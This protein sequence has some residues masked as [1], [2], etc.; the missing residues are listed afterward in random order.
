M[1][2]T[3][4]LASQINNQ[5]PSELVGF[6]K[7]AGETA[8]GRGQKLY[9]VGGV[10]RDLLLKRP[11]LD[12]DL[13]VVGNAIALADE[14]AK[15]KN[16]KVIAHTRFNTAKIR[17]DRWSVDIA[18]TRSEIYEKP[19][20]LPAVQCGGD[21]EGDLIRR[22]FTINAMAVDLDPDHFGGVID[23]F[24]GREDLEGGYIRILHDSSFKD[25]ATRIW[26][27]VR[28]EQRLD[29]NIEPHTL[30]LLKQDITY[31]DAISGDRIRHELELCLEE[32][33]PD[34]VLL[35]ANTFGLLGRICPSLEVAEWAAKKIA[36][37][38]G[39]LQPYSPPEEIYLAFLVYRLTPI[40]LDDLIMYLK[41]SRQLSRILHDTLSLKIQLA[42]LDSPEAAPSRV[43][44]VLHQFRP[45]AILANLLAADSPVIRGKIESYLKTMRSVQ[46][47]LT[48]D[49]L[50]DLGIHSGPRIKETLDLLLEARLDGEV[51]TRQDEIQM[52][53][54]MVKAG[55]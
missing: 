53:E 12:L 39:I 45:T 24:Q 3:T 23:L 32:S 22:D 48:G 18:A 46:P 15:L 2:K 8:E 7:L 28:Y 36:R 9:L 17:W 19:G 55:Q 6:M 54:K 30:D 20:S 52:V 47:A 10:V 42:E 16:G 4:N 5:L 27:A 13:V 44:R 38:R 50:K 40:E 34:K 33:R 25:D 11:N 35:R 29:F 51:E 41:F 1:M 43:Y 49:D 31:L 14:L 21:I 26:R 37:A